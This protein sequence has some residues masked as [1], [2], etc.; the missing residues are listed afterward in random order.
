MAPT[1]VLV[2]HAD[3]APEGGNPDPPLTVA[4]TARAEELRHVLGD[5]GIAAIFHTS[6][7]RSQQTAAPLAAALSV[8][9]QV[10]DD[11]A[12][13]VAALKE[14]ASSSTSLVVGHTDTLPE[15]CASLGGPT[16]P[17]IGAKEFDR[18]FVLAGKRLTRL[19]Y[20]R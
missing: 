5:A 19:R 6:L 1:V 15:I 16:L 8:T 10:I 3:V 14:L 9:P 11:S 20:G 2:R 7:Q 13:V 17:P 18:L 12:G 4:G